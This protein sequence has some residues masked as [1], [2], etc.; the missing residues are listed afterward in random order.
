M[1]KTTLTTASAAL[2]LAAGAV[3]TAGQGP[4]D[5]RLVIDGVEIVTE[6]AP[7][8]GVPLER[9]YSGWRFR[10]DET[11]GLQA[12][13]FENPAMVAISLGPI[14]VRW[15][16]L[17]YMAG[18]LLGWWYIRRLL[19]NRRLWP[20]EPPMAVATADDML[21]WATAGV[22]L[23]GRTGYVLF[24]QP[25][26]YLAN[27]LE[28]FALWHGGMSF[29]GGLLGTALALYIF[30][31]RNGVPYLTVM[32]LGSAAVPI[33]LFFGRIANFIN[34]ELV[35][36]VTDVPWAMVFPGAGPAPR[37]PSQ[38]YEA[39]LEGI[40][41]F[42]VLRFLTH[43]AGALA[44]PGFVTGAFLIGYALARSTG[45]LFR[46]YDPTHIFSLN[47]WITPG[48]VYSIPMLA[49]GLVLIWLA[50]RPA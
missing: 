27:P 1:R 42:L 50:R 14:S 26:Y 43:R 21:I 8:P 3:A 30:A 36:R 18:L 47:P 5:D 35:G 19:A 49:L 45:E 12:D 4:D 41:L 29:H 2:F 39:S 28:I 48:I 15:Y 20:G 23:G 11:Q 44:R 10:S 34:G 7:A 25:L 38:L 32:D 13:D 31:R 37:H 24:Y 6:V 46:Q 16:G 17:A 22:V 33:G 40:A 9:V